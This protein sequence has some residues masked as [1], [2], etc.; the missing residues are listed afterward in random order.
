VRKVV[1]CFLILF[2]SQ[3][4]FG[5][6]LTRGPYLQMGTH[7]AMTVK[8]RTS[9]EGKSMLIYGESYQVKDKEIPLADNSQVQEV[10]LTGLKPKTKYYYSIYQDNVL[11]KGDSTHYFVTS[12]VPG[13]VKE[14]VRMV[15][16]GDCG[17][18]QPAQVEVAKRV[19]EYFG[20]KPIDGWLLLG[21]NAYN[22]GFDNEYQIKFFDIYQSYFLKNTVLWPSPG[23]H[24]YADR[25]WPN[26]IGQK[27]DYFKI[28]NLP[29]KGECGGV[30]SGNAAYYSYDYANVHFVSLDS[31]GTEETK[32]M[33]DTLSK[34]VQWLKKDLAANKLPWTVVYFH[35]PP[36]TKGTHDSDTELDLV[37]IREN[38]VKV[39]DYYKVD[40]V[41]NGHSHNYER[42]FMLYNYFSNELSFNVNSHARGNS[43]AKYDGTPN[44]CPYI[45]SG[46]GTV[47][48]VA[49]ASGM[50]GGTKPGYPHNAMVSSNSETTGAMVL[51]VTDNKFVA[52]YLTANGSIFDQF[53]IFKDVNKKHQK[54]IECGEIVTFESSWKGDIQSTIG[55]VDNGLLRIDSLNKSVQFTISD[56]KNCLHD[57]IQV[58]VKAYKTPKASSNSPIMESETLL[59]EGKFDGNGQLSWK[60]PDNFM[61]IGEKQ[62][63]EK[64]NLNKG[65]KYF[66][67]ASYKNCFSQDSIDVKILK[68]LANEIPK[69]EL[70]K[71]SPN[72]SEGV[73]E[74]E[75][76]VTQEGTY[77]CFLVDNSGRVIN[78][79]DAEKL[80][81][82]PKNFV[83][84]L[85]NKE[86]G[87]YYFILRSSQKIISAK[88]LKK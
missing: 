50:V 37:S 7:N 72:P 23:N 21:D 78:T 12:P 82:G 28:F 18:Q 69:T 85:S 75:V 35:H 27:P 48:V 53:T 24:D 81:V 6:S 63:I 76:N 67:R 30:P 22:Y 33:A 70:V 59:L 25:E 40:V 16:F 3:I 41:L 79:Y 61:A 87:L 15:A 39:L 71:V 26:S 55:K 65:G 5:Q 58:N 45:K 86:S 56:K 17:T 52:K 74:L 11:L 57:T 34:Q 38:L 46:S 14:P 64:V 36:F 60:G 62:I 44:S 1:A 31:Y 54:T 43:S 10:R 8:W 66:L 32:K 83:L 42:S 29:T 4:V 77:E 84:D 20:G 51:E 9:K 19:T 2:S 80:Q 73:F 47:Y 13:S 68:I 88:V 49:G